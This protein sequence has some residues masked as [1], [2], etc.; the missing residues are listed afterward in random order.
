M[1]EWVAHSD[2]DAKRRM[3]LSREI[4]EAIDRFYFNHYCNVFRSGAFA[5]AN[6]SMCVAPAL[7]F[8]SARGGF[9]ARR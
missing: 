7:R 9:L 3:T 6:C 5:R 2:R 1:Q 8:R 4:A